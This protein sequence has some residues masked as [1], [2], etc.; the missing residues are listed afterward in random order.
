M[1]VIEL[2]HITLKLVMAAFDI[3]TLI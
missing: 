3:F 2:R 1:Y